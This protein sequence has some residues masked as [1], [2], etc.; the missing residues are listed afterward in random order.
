MSPS[1]TLWRHVVLNVC[2]AQRQVIASRRVVPMSVLHVTPAA[3][4]SRRMHPSSHP[5]AAIGCADGAMR[6]VRAAVAVANSAT[7]AAALGSHSFAVQS[8]EAER[9]APLSN[10][11]QSTAVAAAV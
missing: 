11:N 1:A 7:R 5:T 3:T 2:T 4:S 9:K 6:K 10:G 8:F